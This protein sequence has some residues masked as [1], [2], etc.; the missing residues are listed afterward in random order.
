MFVLS[1][2]NHYN[3]LVYPYQLEYR[4]GAG[5]SAAQDFLQNEN[6]YDLSQQPQHTYIYGFLYPYL[7]SKAANVYGNTLFVHRSFVYFFI[8]AT[9]MLVFYVLF[10]KKVN[11]V[12]S[13]AAIIILH[14]SIINAANT[15]LARPDG[16]GIFLFTLAI[17]I[18]WRWKF[19]NSSLAVSI[20]L[21]ILGYMTKPY[22]ILAVPIIAAYMF[23]F[24]SKRKSLFYSAV[25]V[26]IFLIWPM[27]T[28]NLFYVLIRLNS[29]SQ[30]MYFF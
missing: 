26:L 20:F 14:Q 24:I 1:L 10:R 22:Y 23:F 15:P 27:V 11:F 17:I 7:V 29:G 19:S 5:L 18:P 16:L 21:S 9:C 2:K 6:P 28:A 12:F 30:I 13:F 8:C 25:S 3:F 4:E